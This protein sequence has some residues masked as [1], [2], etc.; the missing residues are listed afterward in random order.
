MPDENKYS[1]QPSR[2]QLSNAEYHLTPEQTTRVIQA[3]NCLRDR[4]LIQLLAE[5]GVRRS[6]VASLDI[7]DIKFT[8]GFLVIRHGKG[9]KLRLVPMTENL[10]LKIQH[11]IKP[12]MAGPVFQSRYGRHLSVRQ[13]N[14]IVASTGRRAGVRNPNPKYEQITPHL[15]RHSFAR[16]WKDRGGDIETLSK[17]MGHK[18]VKTTWDLYGTQGLSDV[19]R[20]YSQIM[21]K[22][23]FYE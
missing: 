7:E 8:D 6:E 14:R 22:L 18:S 9:Q 13:I 2:S 23:R 4:V 20:N 10:K 3:G 16:L 17:I 12:R 5:T 15:F 1:Q 11:L 19:R 21:H